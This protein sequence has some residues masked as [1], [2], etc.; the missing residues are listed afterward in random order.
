LQPLTP[1]QLAWRLA[2]DLP[3][4]QTLW[5][6]AGLP[7]LLHEFCPPATAGNEGRPIELAVLTADEV[8]ESGHYCCGTP[9]P[10]VV[11]RQTWIVAPLFRA[12]GRPALVEQCSGL[13]QG[14]TPAT[15]LYTDIAIF[16][17]RQGKVFVRAMIEGITL[18]TLQMEL[19]AELHIP[20]DLVLMQIPLS[21]GGSY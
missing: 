7:Q 21:L 5:L 10:L 16:D 18:Q 20:P 11:A 9:L 12:D 6:G 8:S 17:F 3:A 13:L 2:Q 1:R 14:S 19:A 15:R 4:Q